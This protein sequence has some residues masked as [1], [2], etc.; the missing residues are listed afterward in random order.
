MRG[1]PVLRQRGPVDGDLVDD[2][3]GRGSAELSGADPEVPGVRANR[4]V[5]GGLSLLRAVEIQGD[6]G[7][8]IGHHD[9]NDR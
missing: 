3:S 6:V 9:V 8:V 1:D 2:A 7:A 5:I 4:P